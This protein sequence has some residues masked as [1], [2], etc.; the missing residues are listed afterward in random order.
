MGVGT[1]LLDD[2]KLTVRHVEGADPLKVVLDSCLRTP[3]SAALLRETPKRSVFLTTEAAPGDRRRDF[4]R[5][6]ARVEVVQAGADGLVDLG[7][8]LRRLAE[9]GIKSVMVEGGARVITSLLRARLA[10]RLILCVAPIILGRGLEGVGE[11]D[12]ADLAQALDLR[13]L[14]SSAWATI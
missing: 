14:R 3:I 6:G 12:I 8:A 13:N 1:V 2:P 10:D 9:L 5:L 4:E 11:L 7:D